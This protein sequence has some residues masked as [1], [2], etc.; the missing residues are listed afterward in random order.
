[1]VC[2]M[3]AFKQHVSFGFWKA[4]AMKD[5]KQL[6]KGAAKQSPFAIKVSSAKDLPPDDVIVAYVRAAVD[7]NERGVKAS[8]GSG[9][10]K[11]PQPLPALP[12]D[13]AKAFRKSR[14]AKATFDG[15]SPSYKREYLEW[16]LE[17]KR[18]GTRATRVATAIEWM[19]EGK[20]RNW[21]YMQRK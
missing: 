17:A 4:R 2:G 16:I 13:L 8:P 12:D 9:K 20:P 15:F 14:K 11:K 7:L 3:S 10:K 19:A 6:F 21:K 18:E 1:M 5:P